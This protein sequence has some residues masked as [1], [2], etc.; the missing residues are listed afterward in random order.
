MG[1][2][3][4]KLVVI[5]ILLFVGLAILPGVTSIQSNI[6]TESNYVTFDFVKDFSNPKL[7]YS[8]K[9][10]D[11]SVEETNSYV[12][13]DGAPMLPIFSK[14]FELPF[15]AKITDVRISTSKISSMHIN[16]Q[17]KPVP[18]KQKLGNLI[19]NIEGIK[20]QDL[21]A[22]YEPFP[23]NWLDYFTGVGLND[24]NEHV[25]FLT[26]HIYPV[27]YLSLRNVVQYIKKI[28]VSITYNKLD[29]KSLS[30]EST[31]LVVIAPSE[32][33]NNLEPLVSH[34][35]SY[36]IET[37]LITLEDIYNNYSGEDKAEKI[38]YFIKSAIDE[39][40]TKYVLLVGDIKKLPIRTTYASP[41]GEKNILSDLYYA[42]IYDSNFDFCSWDS[43]DNKKFGEVDYKGGFPPFVDDLD[44]VDLYAD[45]HVGRI[46]CTSEKELDI[47]VNKIINYE[48][49]T[50]GKDWFNKIVLAGGDTFPLIRGGHPFVYEGE[51]TNNEVAQQLPEFKHIILWTSKHNLNALTF[52]WAISR[53][54]GFVSYA[55]HGFEMGWGT[56]RPNALINMM[57]FYYTQY[58]VGMKNNDKLPVVFFDACLTAKLDYNI[59]DFENYYPWLTKLLLTLTKLENDPSIFY[60]CFAWSFLKK[61]NGG[62]IA[63]IGATRVAYT[64]VDKYGVHAGAGYLDVQFFK[65]YDKNVTAGE[66]L[67]QAQKNYINDVGKDYFTIEEYLL[68]GDPSLMV[69]GYF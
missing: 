41:W 48:K 49:E 40:N 44:G 25:L 31:D 12:N 15:G 19:I 62:S 34:K 30:T 23:T 10:L 13:Y 45:V 21:Y 7:I 8:E 61:E 56:Y 57:I 18:T 33:L 11:I 59:T 4:R 58:L 47:V 54:A 6:I 20:S 29:F 1:K 22:S 24:N 52:N 67:T 43:N 65:A 50:Y 42:D 36:G 64:H 32:F 14:T 35:S 46:P 17:I 66:M 38:K 2:F 5:I 9:F 37:K 53:G 26:L 55:G 63:T 60:P 3:E 68:L 28:E 16:K 51:I 27:R 39:W 69:G